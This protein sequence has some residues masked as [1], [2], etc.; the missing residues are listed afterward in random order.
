MKPEDFVRQIKRRVFD[1][2]VRDTLSLLESP[3][4]REPSQELVDLSKWYGSLPDA[5]K[6]QVVK[7]IQTAADLAVFGMLA[8]LDGARTIFDDAGQG[9][10]ELYYRL[11]DASTLLNSPSD[12]YL[13]DRFVDER[14]T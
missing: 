7:T 6:E 14:S 11:G 8:V 10:F 5:D 13:H 9:R 1:A 3:P 4:G 2:A 12:E